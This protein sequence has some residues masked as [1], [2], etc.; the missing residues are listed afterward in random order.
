[1]SNFK[2]STNRAPPTAVTPPPFLQG[3]D[4][5]A[6]CAHIVVYRH[7]YQSQ[8]VL[9]YVLQNDPAFTNLAS[10]RFVALEEVTL[11]VDDDS[12]FFFHQLVLLFWQQIVIDDYHANVAQKIFSY[13]KPWMF[14]TL[15]GSFLPI[16][17]LFRAFSNY[18]W[19][20]Q[21]CHF[22][23]KIV[24]GDYKANVAQKFFPTRNKITG[25]FTPGI[26]KPLPGDKK[27][28]PLLLCSFTF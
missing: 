8:I 1:M 16:G 12:N 4:A 5:F 6:L 19:L 26:A 13:K 9:L 17:I 18:F 25:W 22:R 2:T 11:V 10:L 21:L 28:P 15:L 24:I 3:S 14:H 20:G 23:Q 27:R 7:V